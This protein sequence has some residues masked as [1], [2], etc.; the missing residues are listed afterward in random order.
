M[1]KFSEYRARRD[2]ELLIESPMLAHT[3]T[4]DVINVG[5]KSLT[6]FIVNNH[7]RAS[8]LGN[9]RF[10]LKHNS[11]S[12]IYYHNIDGKPMELSFIS[13]HKQVGA[14]KGTVG[15][16]SH[17]HRFMQHHVDTFGELHSSNS[18]TNGSK[19]LW[20][21]FI[22]KNKQFKFSANNINGDK[23]KIDHANIDQEKDKIWGEKENF[24][25]ITIS[26]HK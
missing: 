8:K 16:S 10:H 23:H 26:V 9:D 1:G 21:D 12:D 22:K 24:A 11:G 6:D 20:I 14:T 5:S 3:D 13:K 15:D 2:Q 25:N 18:N 7:D 19:K 4:P 17:I